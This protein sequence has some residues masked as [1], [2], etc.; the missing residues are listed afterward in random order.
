MEILKCHNLSKIYEY[1]GGNLKAVNEVSM[2]IH[3]GESIAIMGPSGCGKTTLISMLGGLLKPSSG[4][5]LIESY[6]MGK[7]NEKKKSFIRN[8]FFGF[9]LQRFALIGNYSVFKNCEIPLLFSSQKYKRSERR[10]MITNSL[11]SFNME[12]YINRKVRNLSGGE[13]QRVAL[14]RAIV[15]NPKVIF[16]DEPTG[17]LDQANSKLIVDHLLSLVNEERS[18][19]IVTHDV[20][21][22]SRCSRVI[23]MKDGKIDNNSN[24]TDI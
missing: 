22:A 14:A 18:I 15:N 6:E 9:V 19:V 1:E 5:I 20:N 24:F 3:A 13:S 4:E 16:A 23:Y 2:V 10:K 21:V 7:L 11:R 8:Q 12:R 17:S